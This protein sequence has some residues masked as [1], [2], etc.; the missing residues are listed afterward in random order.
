MPKI[1]ENVRENLLQEARKQV[2]EQGYSAFTIRSVATAC[3]LGVG[4]VYNYFSSKDVLVA[5]FMLEDWQQCRKKMQD[6]C[7]GREPA[8]AL[9]CVY[10]SLQEFMVLY[11]SLFNDEQ[12]GMAFAKS[13]GDK[14]K[15]LRSQIAEPLLPI[16]T[17]QNRAEAEYLSEFVA[18]SMLTWTM[19]GYEFSKISSVL[20]QLF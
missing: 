1:L 2:M 3:G 17:K 14:H 11:S 6:G 15:L 9:C 20:L 8:E 12:A 10:E 16:C 13:F 4:T 5:S 18:E 19:E 7:A